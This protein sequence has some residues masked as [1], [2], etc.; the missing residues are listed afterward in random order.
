MAKKQSDDTKILKR[1]RKILSVRKRWIKKVYAR[2]K[3][4]NDLYGSDSTAVCFC[5]EGAVEK[6][7]KDLNLSYGDSTIGLLYTSLPHSRGDY[8][9]IYVYNDAPKRKHIE[10]LRWFDR[11]IAL[12]EKE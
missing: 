9:T 1:A 11:A 4:G 10:V 12:S 5:A 8:S 2:D 7:A 3:D 6:A